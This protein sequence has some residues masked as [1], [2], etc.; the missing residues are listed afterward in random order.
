MKKSR[1]IISN[2]IRV[3]QSSSSNLFNLDDFTASTGLETKKAKS[4]LRK[5]EKENQ[6]VT[7]SPDFFLLKPPQ[8]AKSHKKAYDWHPNKY[9]L[10]VL[11]NAIPD[12]KSW[13]QSSLLYDKV[14]N[15]FSLTTFSRYLRYL[16]HLHYV[17]AKIYKYNK[18]TGRY[19]FYRKI[20][21]IFNPNHL[22]S[23]YETI[24]GGIK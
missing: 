1:S 5:A 7:L 8:K 18:Y 19:Y 23:W 11:L 9:K 6:I 13:I 15:I 22:K 10:Q 21:P 2:F 24:K 4:I 16:I 17:E 3:M 14:K 20:K 12:D